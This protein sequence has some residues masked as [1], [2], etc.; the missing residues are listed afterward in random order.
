[1]DVTF[2]KKIPIIKANPPN[3]CDFSTDLPRH[4][5]IFPP[6]PQIITVTSACVLLPIKD[7]A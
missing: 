3:C 5:E 6:V 1:M 2:L 4:R 7:S